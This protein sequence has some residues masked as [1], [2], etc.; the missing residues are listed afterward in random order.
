MSKSQK[1][2]IPQQVKSNPILRKLNRPGNSDL[3]LPSKQ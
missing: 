2:N 1:V 3:M